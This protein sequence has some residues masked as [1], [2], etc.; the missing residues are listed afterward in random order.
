VNLDGVIKELKSECARLERAIA[1]LVSSVGPRAKPGK[2]TMESRRRRKPMSA[3]A[4]KRLSIAMKKRWA[5]R[6]R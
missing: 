2:S 5:E 3:A 6:R 4:R 1:A